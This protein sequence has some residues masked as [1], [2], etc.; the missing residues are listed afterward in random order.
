MSTSLLVLTGAVSCY[1]AST[2]NFIWFTDEN[3]HCISTKQ[4]RG[5]KLNVSWSKTQPYASLVC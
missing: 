5:I 1:P 3:V 2:V 4:H